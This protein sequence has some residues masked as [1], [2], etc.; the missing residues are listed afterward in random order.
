MASADEPPITPEQ[1][2]E[3]LLGGPRRHRRD[4]VAE[5]AGVPV[6]HARRL[7]RAV[8]FA[9]VGDVA[10]AFTDRDLEALTRVQGLVRDGVL[11]DELAVSVT[12]AMGH[13]AA[14][15]VEWLYDALVEHL[16]DEGWRWRPRPAGPS[17]W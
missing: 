15:L 17:S 3:R 12:R 11:D 16:V 6:E 4:Q 9:D 10:V 14:R 7:W 8:G 13:N 5:A 1:V 2:E